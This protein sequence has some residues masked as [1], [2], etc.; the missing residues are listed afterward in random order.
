[1]TVVSGLEVY[2]TLIV[3][4]H[5]KHLTEIERDDR[6]TETWR[7]MEDRWDGRNANLAIVD[8]QYLVRD[9]AGYIKLANKPI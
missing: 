5:Y 1:M 2:K 3:R 4:V 8:S 7:E 9:N 6:P